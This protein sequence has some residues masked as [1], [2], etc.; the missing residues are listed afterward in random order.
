MLSGRQCS[1][2]VFGE[3]LVGDLSE[4]AEARSLLFVAAVTTRVPFSREHLLAEGPHFI[5]LPNF[6]NR[7]LIDVPEGLFSFPWRL[8]AGRNGAVL[9]DVQVNPRH[10]AKGI[11]CRSRIG[12]GKGLVLEKQ[13]F[14][15]T[16]VFMLSGTNYHS[17]RTM[18]L[19]H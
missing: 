2:N 13:A 17:L 15:D 10:D 8:T 18:S 19:F 16:H 6:S 12:I 14:E 4:R 5:S 3:F 11:R 9:G 1:G 7:L